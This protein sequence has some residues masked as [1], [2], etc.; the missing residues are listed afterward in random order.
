MIA[1]IQCTGAMEKKK[2][3]FFLKFS[4]DISAKDVTIKYSFFC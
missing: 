3:F 1:T 2:D 4:F